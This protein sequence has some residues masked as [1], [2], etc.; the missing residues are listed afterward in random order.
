MHEEH[1]TVRPV[2]DGEVDTYYRNGWVLLRGLVDRATVKAMLDYLT[3]QLGDDALGELP[4]QHPTKLI[5]AGFWRD[6]RFLARDEH[7]EP[8]HRL[9]FGSELARNA[10]RLIDRRVPTRFDIDGVLIKIPESAGPASTP[11]EWHQDFPNCA[12]DRVGELVVWIALH[13]MAP[14]CGTL[15]F[16]TG[17]QREGPLG[18][19]LRGGA[20]LVSQYPWLT[21]RYNCSMPLRLNAGDATVHHGLMVHSA[22]A[23]TSARP[24]WTYAINYFPADVCYTGAAFS[25][26]DGLGLEIGKPLDHPRFPVVWA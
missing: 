12:H 16:L 19:T 10:H 4:E 23:N 21:E 20:D 9:C 8:F 15:R 5:E 25:N 3:S 14:E 11:T 26:T 2:T 13:D 1:V 17:S 6:W 24:R 7:I 22:P 18:R